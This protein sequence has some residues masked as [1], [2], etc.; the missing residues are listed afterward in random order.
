MSTYRPYGCVVYIIIVIFV[1]ACQSVTPIPALPTPPDPNM[2]SPSR[3][4]REGFLVSRVPGIPNVK[5]VDKDQSKLEFANALEIGQIDSL[6][7]I[8][9]ESKRDAKLKLLELLDSTNPG[10]TEIIKSGT[11]VVIPPLNV[12][13]LSNITQ[14]RSSVSEPL[15]LIVPISMSLDKVAQKFH[16]TIERLRAANPELGNLTPIPANMVLIIPAQ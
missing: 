4:A 13:R 14:F 7:I 8:S 2:A 16:V 12:K 3:T 15:L 11:L 1:A 6:P 5:I 10:L 9:I